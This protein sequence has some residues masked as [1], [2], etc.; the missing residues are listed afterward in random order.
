MDIPW[1]TPGSG[2]ECETCGGGEGREG[3]LSWAVLSWGTGRKCLK[4]LWGGKSISRL[5]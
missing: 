5:I 2:S 1:W 3:E 4:V